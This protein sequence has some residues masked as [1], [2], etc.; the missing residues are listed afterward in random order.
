MLT[1]STL[2]FYARVVAGKLQRKPKGAYHH[3]DLECA[4]VDAALQT[5]R[6]E[7]VEA[8][9]LRDVAARLGV[10]R[11]ALYRHF[12]D[13][14]ALLA[15]VALEGFRLFRQALQS[16]IDRA[17]SSGADPMEEMGV[18]YV[19]FAMTNQSH[20]KTMFGSAIGDWEQYPDLA[21]EADGAFAVLLNTIV[22]EQRA[23][24]IVGGDPVPLAHVIWAGV[25]GLAML[26][27]AGCL[28]RNGGA[29]I[30]LTALVR[31]HSRILLDGLRRTGSTLRTKR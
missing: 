11:T 3:P 22:E 9:T 19:A 17:R 4:L 10:S 27:L 29:K 6:R 16:A 1:L 12:K 18:A 15:R 25:H 2:F 8:L 20:Y 13:K 7:G 23:S 5:I 28:D 14:S 26:E 21:L 31:L 24:R 30:D